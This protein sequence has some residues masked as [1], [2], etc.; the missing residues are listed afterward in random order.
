MPIVQ[1]RYKDIPFEEAAK[2]STPRG[3]LANSRDVW[4]QQLRGKPLLIETP[5]IATPQIEY[6]CCGGPFYQVAGV[7]QRYM[8]CVHI[9]E[10]GD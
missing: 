4:E 10:I 2:C 5:P 6:A 8:A 3:I 9:A 7:E 1:T